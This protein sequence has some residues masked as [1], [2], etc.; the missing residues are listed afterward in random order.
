[1]VATEDSVAVDPEES[2]ITEYPESTEIT[3]YHDEDLTMPLE[4]TVNRGLT[5]YDAE[6]GT[7][8][9]TKVAFPKD[10]PIVISDNNNALPYIIYKVEEEKTQYR[11]KPRGSNLQ[12]GDAKPYKNTK[13]VF[14]CKFVPSFEDA[15][16]VF[17]VYVTDKFA[18]GDIVNIYFPTCDSGEIKDREIITDQNP[19]DFTGQVFFQNISFPNAHA[20]FEN[21]GDEGWNIRTKPEKP[22]RSGAEP[23][24][25]ATVTIMSGPRRGENTTTNQNGQYIFRNVREDNLH[26]LVEK[27]CYEPKEVI[28]HQSRPTILA[29]GDRPNYDEDIQKIPG[30]ILIGRE[31]PDE[32]RFILTETL[33]VYDLLLYTAYPGQ[34][35]PA[36]GLYNPQSGTIIVA[37]T[38]LGH[39]RPGFLSLIAHEIAHA[40]QYALISVDGSMN[41]NDWENTS[42]GRAFARARQKDWAEVGKTEYDNLQGFQT[43][44]ENAAETCAYYWSTDKWG[45]GTR[46]GNL[47]RIAPN[48]F[49]WA[50]EWLTKK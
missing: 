11:I 24:A 13:H 15:G 6:V 8:L 38:T 25:T 19:D 36:P 45:K 49:K 2:V 3:Y 50:K 41:N 5:F 29:N 23:L 37:V 18:A 30:N 48:R 43:L 47:K 14:V 16:S 22:I 4:G 20:P 33:L 26:L 32:V 9:Y 28:V 46:Y 42:E 35:M 34:R 40:H 31:W 10:V 17:W 7:A 27:D 12:S 44:L 39:G 21:V 1:M